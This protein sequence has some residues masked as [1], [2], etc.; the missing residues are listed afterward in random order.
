[1]CG[2]IKPMLIGHNMYF[3]FIFIDDYSR[4]TL[5]Y[6]L[7]RKSKVLNCFKEFKAI[8]KMKSGYNIKTMRF[9]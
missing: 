6:F 3:F 4:K 5:V 8:I 7:K 1:V 9:D 2:P